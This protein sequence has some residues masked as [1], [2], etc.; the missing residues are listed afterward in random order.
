MKF[1]SSVFKAPEAMSHI[2]VA[3]S[4]GE[5]CIALNNLRHC[6]TDRISATWWRTEESVAQKYTKKHFPDAMLE[7]VNIERLINMI[8]RVM[9][10]RRI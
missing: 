4:V 1:I 10:V 9:S 7:F 3:S 8:Y 5:N 2:D 6:S